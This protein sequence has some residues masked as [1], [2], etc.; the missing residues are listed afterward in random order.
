M[1]L[2][3]FHD[4]SAKYVFLPS[5]TPAA[6]RVANGFAASYQGRRLDPHVTSEGGEGTKQIKNRFVSF[7]TERASAVANVGTNPFHLP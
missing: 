2:P 5:G 3:G 7:S 4:P 1:H 6:N